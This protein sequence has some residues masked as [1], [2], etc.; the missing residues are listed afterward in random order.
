MIDVHV[1]IETTSTN[2]KL[3]VHWRVNR[4]STKREREGVML[5]LRSAGVRQLGPEE[6]AVVQLERVSRGRLDSDNLQGA[7]KAVRDEV[8]KQLG[9]DDGS[10]RVIYE[11]SQ[12]KGTKPLVH[13]VIRGTTGHMASGVQE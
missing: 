10:D 3:R 9:V 13:I 7:L 6:R 2:S 11:Y 8:A 5:M 4:A 12:T 1:P